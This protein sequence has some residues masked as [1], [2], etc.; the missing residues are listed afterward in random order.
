MP[1]DSSNNQNKG[2]RSN[3]GRD[4][5]NRGGSYSP[6]WLKRSR[7]DVPQTGKPLGEN[8]VVEA[9]I[10]SGSPGKEHAEQPRQPA[11]Q[12]VSAESEG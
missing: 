8:P 10:A 12:Q 4:Q 3:G 11:P 6:E 1:N 5:E 2:S 7:D 9:I